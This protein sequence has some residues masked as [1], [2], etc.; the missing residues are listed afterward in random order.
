MSSVALLLGWVV[1]S[2][3][4]ASPV[5]DDASAAT[6]LPIG[7]VAP[8]QGGASAPSA[9]ASTIPVDAAEPLDRPVSS[10]A[11]PASSSIPITGTRPLPQVPERIEPPPDPKSTRMVRQ[12]V[13][14]GPV[15]RVRPVDTMVT[16]GATL[17]HEHGLSGTV[18][19]GMILAS[20]RRQVQAFDFPFGVG[21]V[22]RARLGHR[23]VY[24]SVGLTAGLLV[25]RAR[26]VLG[27]T[28]RVDPDL[29]LPLRFDW[30][31]SAATGLSLAFVP[32]YSVRERSY[33]RRGAPVWSRSAVRLGLVIGLHWDIVQRRARPRRQVDRRRGGER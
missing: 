23:S 7:G 21:A 6:E 27:V 9:P 22:Y 15:W 10:D 14:L 2:S 25:H 17:G 29:R 16:T 28:H 32:G 26:T 3:A 12:D 5:D 8:L 4:P 19:A 18:H 1:I 13:M 11:S 31:I 33:L 20:D 24:G 30:T